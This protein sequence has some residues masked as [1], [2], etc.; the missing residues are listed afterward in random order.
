MKIS[1]YTT[2]RVVTMSQYSR[3]VVKKHKKEKI[4]KMCFSCKKEDC[5]GHCEYL[6]GYT[7]EEQN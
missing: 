2:I 4:N 5:K 6:R 1:R 3:N 7:N